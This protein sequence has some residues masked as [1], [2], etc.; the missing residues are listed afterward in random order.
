MITYNNWPLYHFAGDSAPGDTNGQGLN[1]V[2]FVV[3]ADGEPITG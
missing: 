1:D 2:W 3:G